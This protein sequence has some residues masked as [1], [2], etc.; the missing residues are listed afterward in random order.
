MNSSSNKI[1]SNVDSVDFQ[2]LMGKSS[3]LY[4]CFLGLFAL[5]GTIRTFKRSNSRG[6]VK[7]SS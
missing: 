1:V 5:M 6:L 4:S 7:D 3:I 2:E